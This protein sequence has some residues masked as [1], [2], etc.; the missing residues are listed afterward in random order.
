M[1][2]TSDRRTLLAQIEQQADL[3]PLSP[4]DRDATLLNKL[5]YPHVVDAYLLAARP[6]PEDTEELVHD[7]R[8]ASRRLVEALAL[9]SPLLPAKGRKRA[10]KHAKALRR[11]LGAGREADVM[12]ADLLGLVERAGLTPETIN[13]C[14][15]GDG[16]SSLDE[17]AAAFP[18]ERLLERA[19]DILVMAATP[20]EEGVTTRQLAGP[21]LV[22]RAADAADYVESVKDPEALA[23]HHRLRIRLKRLRYTVEMI[24]PAFEDEI[25]GKAAVKLL[26]SLQDALGAQND[27]KDL[28]DWLGKKRAKRALGDARNVLAETAAEALE[29]RRVAA[30]DLVLEEAPGLIAQLDRSAGVIGPVLR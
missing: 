30:R 13:D 26:K 10:E 9:A 19:V 7:V 8:V 2:S 4:D 25:D 6:W 23:D 21:H 18:P 11:A 29:A 12:R 1:A 14:K 27:M 28:V 20:T 17:V 5:L 3:P 16:A 24:A 15:F 22:R